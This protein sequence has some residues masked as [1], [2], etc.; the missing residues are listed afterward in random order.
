MYDFGSKAANVHDIHSAVS[1]ERMA[2]T[3]THRPPEEVR[4]TIALV[5]SQ[6]LARDSFGDALF[7]LLVFGH[8][9]PAAPSERVR[10]EIRAY[11]QAFS[12]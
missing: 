12:Q 2:R 1:A 7:W 6:A 9:G 5:L 4:T 11:L 8:W 10:A 3:L